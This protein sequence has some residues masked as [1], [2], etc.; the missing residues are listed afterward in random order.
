MGSTVPKMGRASEKKADLASTLFSQAQLRVLSLLVGHPDQKFYGSEIIRLAQSGSGAVQ[1]E[2]A[3]LT[4]AGILNVASSGNRKVYQANKQSPIFKELRG[5]ILKTVG[6]IEPIRR[7][8]DKFKGK[9][10]FAFVYGSIAKGSDTARSDIDLIIVGNE[11][12][13]SEVFGT[14]QKAEQALHRPVNPNLMTL[15]EWKQKLTNN[16]AFVRKVQEQPKLF[17]FGTNNELNRTG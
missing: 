15:I 1:R 11:L 7:A 13:Y 8:L 5:I 12:E 17:V 16:N 14:L 6:L 4:K 2:L 10:D 9:I 3:K